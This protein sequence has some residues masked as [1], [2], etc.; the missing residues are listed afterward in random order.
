MEITNVVVFTGGSQY[1]A[2]RSFGKEVAKGFSE[3]GVNVEILYSDDLKRYELYKRLSQADMIVSFNASGFNRLVLQ[4]IF[5][6]NNV[7]CWSFM[8]D[9]PYYHHLELYNTTYNQI[10]S[11]VDREHLEYLKRYYPHIKYKYFVPHGCAA[12]EIMQIDFDDRTYDISFFGSYRK[13]EKSLEKLN[14]YS[15]NMQELLIEAVENVWDGKE[16]TLDNSIKDIFLKYDITDVV[17][18]MSDIMAEFS[19]LDEYIRNERRALL[20]RTALKAGRKVHIFGSGWENFT[21][22]N[23]NNLIVHGSVDFDKSLELMADSKIVLNNMPLFANGSHERV[24]S[25]MSSGSVCLTDSN[26]YLK[27]NF[28]HGEDIFYFD[29]LNIDDL[30]NLIENILNKD[31]DVDRIIN[32]GRNKALS[33]HTWAERVKEILEYCKTI[34]YEKNQGLYSNAIDQDMYALFNYI[35]STEADILY[36]QIKGRYSWHEYY[37]V[38]Y[39]K[40]LYNSMNRY[41]FW[42]SWNPEIGDYGIIKE[43]VDVLKN[44]SESLKLLYESLEDYSSKKVLCNVLLNWVYFSPEYLNKIMHSQYDHYFDYDIITLSPDEVFVD[45][46]AYTGD[47]AEEFMRE[48]NCRFNKIYCYEFSKRNVE[49]LNAVAKID[50]RIIVRPFAIGDKKGTIFVDA[51]EDA[52]SDRIAGD[53]SADGLTEVRMVSLDEDIK[54]KVTFIKSDIEGAEMLA[55]KG[56]KHHIINDH[57]KLAIS[58]YHGNYDIY[59]VAEYIQSLDASYRFYMRYYGGSLYPNEIVL[60]AV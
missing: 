28:K 42:G 1:D 58:V 51:N 40:N 10:V 29:W 22:E 33:E 35:N 27:E 47:T 16:Q 20:I 6:R 11:V 55:L 21:S 5:N 32:N 7:V 54:E 52:S 26:P 3:N 13:S 17:D 41:R 34:E 31:Y 37:N 57:P 18:S 9:H 60:Y 12:D 14:E 50:E 48:T 15:P 25:I 23:E 4:E 30:P 24:F 53:V 43:R 49:K 8:V 39:T 45:L 44:H 46:G 56:A 59:R 38:E 36:E 2:M 19:F